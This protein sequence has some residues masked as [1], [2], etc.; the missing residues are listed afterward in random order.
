MLTIHLPG[1]RLAPFRGG[2][3]SFPGRGLIA[4]ALGLGPCSASAAPADPLP[5][6]AWPPPPAEP[7]VVYVRTITGPGD[8]GVKPSKL[9]RFANWIT[10]VRRNE[11]TLDKPFGLSLD[12]SGNLMVTDTGANQ[13]C[14]LDF[15]RKKWLR[16]KSVGQQRLVSPVAAVHRDRTFFVADSALGEVL[17]FD[18][19]GKL[20]FAITNQ[21]ERPAGLALAGDRLI[22]ADAQR[23]QIVFFGLD[24]RFISKFGHRGKGPGEFNFP[25]HV[26]VDGQGQVYVTDSMNCRIQVFD[27]GGQFLR[28]FGSVGDGPGRFSRPKGVAVDNA[29]HVYVVDSL[30]ENVQIFDGVGRLLLDWGEPGSTTGRFW[31]PNAIAINSKNEIFVADVYNHRIQVFRYTGKP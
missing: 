24:G 12:A 19:K 2:D 6:T 30:F 27:A 22:V 10:G 18:E 5:L 3:F 31:L 11:N 14:Y 29:G 28:A 26:N 20:Q 23:H 15:T 8:I 16:W 13:V 21:L 1:F 7:Y 9:L 17:A 25:T 4:F